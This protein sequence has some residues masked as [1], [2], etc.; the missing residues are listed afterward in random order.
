MIMTTNE[1]VAKL[2]I[3]RQENLLENEL[4]KMA[5]T[6][7]EEQNSKIETLEDIIARLEEEEY[8]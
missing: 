7:L 2:E 8:D 5:I 1:L 6:R 4:I 3:W